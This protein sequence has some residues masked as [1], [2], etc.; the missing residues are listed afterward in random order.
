MDLEKLAARARSVLNLLSILG[1]AVLGL[2]IVLIAVIASKQANFAAGLSAALPAIVIAG[3]GLVVAVAP[4]V[5]SQLVAAVYK[6]AIDARY[7]SEQLQGS[8]ENQRHLLE[9]LRELNSLSDAAKQIAYRA[10]DLAVLRQAIREDMDKGDFEAAMT[11][12]NEMERRFGYQK[13]ADQFR[14]QIQQTSKAAIDARV[15]ETVEHVNVLLARFEF[16]EA[17]READRLLRTF[18]NHPE[19]RR[20]PDRIADVRDSHKRDLLKQWKDAIAKDDVDRSVDLLRQLDQYLSPSEAT[21]YKEMARDVFKKRLQQLGVQFALH[22][23]DKNWSEALRIGKQ[24]TDEF[25]NT[26][27]ASEVRERMVILQEK[28]AQPLAV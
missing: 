18:A 24:I 2:G 16:A 15:R 28:A 22:V 17:D 3:F 4:Q 10:K 21:A 13:E 9:N 7:R 5:A 23:H 6:R 11:L 1:I 25:P 14:E 8:L 27:M 26:R 12:V 19:A 20:L